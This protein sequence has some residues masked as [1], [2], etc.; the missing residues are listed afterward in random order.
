MRRAKGLPNQWPEQKVLRQFRP[1]ADHLKEVFA[2]SIKAYFES[3][4]VAALLKQYQEAI[5]AVVQNTR[6]FEQHAL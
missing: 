2:P 4:A 5:N 1:K 3:P 6:I